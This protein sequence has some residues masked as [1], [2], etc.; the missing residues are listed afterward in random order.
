MLAR[1]I[2]VLRKRKR[3]GGGGGEGGGKREQEGHSRQ[4]S[5]GQFSNSRHGPHEHKAP[6]KNKLGVLPKG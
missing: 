2:G 1:D 5:A 6:E 3:E 4:G